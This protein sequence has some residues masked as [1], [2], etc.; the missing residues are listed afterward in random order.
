MNEFK[1]YKALLGKVE[2]LFCPASLAQNT[3]T[4][5]RHQ[6]DILVDDLQ[7]ALENVSKLG[8]E[9]M[10]ESQKTGS[11]NQIGIKDP[12]GNSIVLKEKS[13]N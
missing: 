13:D 1:L 9:V 11:F 4:Q 5:N 12:D 8:G 6:L 2:I 10:G 7:S 3:A